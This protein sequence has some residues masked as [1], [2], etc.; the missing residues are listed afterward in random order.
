MLKKREVAT[1]VWEMTDEGISV[2]C[3]CEK[4]P[5]CREKGIVYRPAEPE[6]IE[7]QIKRLLKS[8]QWEY[9]V[10]DKKIRYYQIRQNEPYDELKLKVPARWKDPAALEQAR[11]GFEK[12]RERR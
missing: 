3:W 1:R 9:G 5:A 8:F 10:P 11:A 12:L 2:M 4:G 7:S 6:F